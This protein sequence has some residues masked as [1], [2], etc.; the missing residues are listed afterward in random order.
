VKGI[1][2]QLDATTR[3]VGAARAAA[4]RALGDIAEDAL[5]EANRTVP[6]E[7]GTL[8]RS[9]T[10][11]VDPAN[12]QAAV[13]YDT[14]YAVRQHEDPTLRH[15]A[16]RRSHWLQRTVEEHRDRYQAYYVDQLKEVRP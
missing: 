5:R 12:L 4:V 16:G 10:A 1:T 15:D 9:G 11:Q 6:L 7:E 13:G 8:A 2:I 3:L 14:P